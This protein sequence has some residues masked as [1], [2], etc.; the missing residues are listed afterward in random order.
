MNDSCTMFWTPTRTA[1]LE[2]LDAFS[3]SMGRHYAAMRNT[4]FGPDE[5]TNTSLLSPYLR[6]RLITEH[7]AVAAALRAHGYE[8]SEKFVQE[9]FWRTYFKGWLERR[10]TVWTHYKSQLETAKFRITDDRLLR[11]AETGSTG[12]AC[13]DAWARELVETHYLHNHARMWFASIW[14][15]TLKLPWELGADFFMRHL[16]DGDPASNTL[17]WR[18][19]AGLHTRGKNYVAQPWNIAKFTNGR[20]TPSAS[21]LAEDPEPLTEAF[22]PGLAQPVRKATPF[23]PSQKTALLIT[24]EDCMSETLG[25][26]LGNMIAA[27]TLCVTPPQ[28]V[29]TIYKFNSASLADAAKRAVGLGAPA[30]TILDPNNPHGLADWAQDAGAT[31]IVTSYVP[32]GPTRDWLDQAASSLDNAGIT[33]AEI[34]R[35]WDETV[36]P[37][38]S[39]GFFK[40]KKQIPRLIQDLYPS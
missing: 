17:S 18:W 15:F 10:P 6:R 40:V 38:A 2:Q 12:I 8:G 7:E 23:D 13:F 39:A 35:N 27:A 37:L 36:W 28:V 25:P 22:D 29:K 14:I 4:D 19:V 20:F 5:R 31:Q 16:L 11:E 21:E 9:V 24:I 34:T 26:S 1:A 32:I 3:P 33:L 30:M